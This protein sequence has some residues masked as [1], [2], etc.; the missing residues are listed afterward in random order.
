MALVQG[1]TC[2]TLS[3]TRDQ[4]LI[5]EFKL[6]G[7]ELT[8][9]GEE[10]PP[11]R[12]LIGKILTSRIEVLKFDLSAIETKLVLCSQK[13]NTSITMASLSYQNFTIPDMRDLDSVCISD[14]IERKCMKLLEEETLTHFRESIKVN[15]DQR[16]EIA[17]P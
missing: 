7:I 12:L 8:N 9:I 16:Y 3:S 17:L 6:R 13:K 15:K 10:N 4:N 1:K 11:I 2:T 14:P 5:N